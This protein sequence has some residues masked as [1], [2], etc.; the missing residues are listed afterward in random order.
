MPAVALPKVA[1]LLFYLRLNPNKSFRYQTVAVIVLCFVYLVAL[2][3]VQLF[4]CKPVKKLWQPLIPGKC[5][6]EDPVYLVIPIAGTILDVFVLLLPI[7]M[8]IKLQVNLRTK[9]TLGAVF[10]FCSVTVVISAMRIWST[11]KIQ[12]TEDLTWNAAV[13]NCLT[14]AEVNLMIVCG[15]IMVLRPF[16]RRHLPFIFGSDKSRP[17]DEMMGRRAN[18][19][20]FDY[21]MGNA[22]SKSDYRAKISGGRSGNFSGSKGTGKRNIWGGLTSTTLKGDDD[23]LESLSAELKTLAPNVRVAGRGGP[24]GPVAKNRYGIDPSTS[25][26]SLTPVNTQPTGPIGIARSDSGETYAQSGSDDINVGHGG[27]VKT[28]S[29]DVR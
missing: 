27:I 23:D 8:L 17:T 2:L 20:N 1:I 5:I 15:S 26:K 10:A 22:N 29:L 11:S 24:R 21:P 3:L 25:D 12:G 18:G 19:I 9:L 16:C 13:S 28:V 14:V 7:P 6:N 4:A